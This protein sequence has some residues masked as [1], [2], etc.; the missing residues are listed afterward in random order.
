MGNISIRLNN[1]EEK[2]FKGY[3]KITGKNLSTLFKQSLEDRIETEYDLKL[4]RA[5]H[6]E[7]EKDTETISHAD[8][9]KELG[10]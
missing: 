5:A 8:F 9:K 6:E 1:E 2:Y 3:A 7:Y 4:Y 10:L